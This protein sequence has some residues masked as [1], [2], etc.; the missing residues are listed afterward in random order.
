VEKYKQVEE[1][2]KIEREKKMCG[3]GIL[4]QK[5]DRIQWPKSKESS[6]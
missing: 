6:R 1:S 3:N 2:T 4:N 5:I